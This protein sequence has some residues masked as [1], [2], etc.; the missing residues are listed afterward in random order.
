[1]IDVTDEIL[2][3]YIEGE[4]DAETVQ[5]IK[6]QISKSEEVRTRFNALM[7][8]HEELKKIEIKETKRNFTSMVMAKIIKPAKVRKSDK[9]FILSIS[10][11]FVIICLVIVGIA[12]YYSAVSLSKSGQEQT[13]LQNILSH[14]EYISNFIKDIFNRQSISVIGSIMSF[15][16]IISGYFYF[17]NKKKYNTS[18]S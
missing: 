11:I 4:L 16:I 6:N 13:L 2:N 10:G 18:H 5:E 8:V 1:M 14:S 12:V 7:K 15:L 3:R 17:E 9:A